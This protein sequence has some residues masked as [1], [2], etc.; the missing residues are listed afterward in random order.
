MIYNI[1]SPG[2]STYTPYN[3]FFI[4]QSNDVTRTRDLGVMTVD[5]F[6]FWSKRLSESILREKGLFLFYTSL[7]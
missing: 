3:D 1:F 4:G 7:S 6:Q 2:L 5:D